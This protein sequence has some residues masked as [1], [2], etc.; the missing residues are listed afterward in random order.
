MLPNL[1]ELLQE[2]CHSVMVNKP[3]NDESANGLARL[4]TPGV[5]NLGE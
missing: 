5:Q 3:A 2:T 4:F 1:P